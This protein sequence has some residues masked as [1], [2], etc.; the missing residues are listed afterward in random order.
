[1][2]DHNTDRSMNAIGVLF[3]AG[4]ILLIILGFMPN[5]IT[6]LAGTANGVD[7][8]YELEGGSSTM[9][10]RYIGVK[11]EHTVPIE[12]P[13]Y[14]SHHFSGWLNSVDEEI[15]FPGETFEPKSDTTM[16][17]VWRVRQ[18]DI[19]YELNGGTGAF[20]VERVD[21]FSTYKLYDHEPTREGYTFKGWL[22]SKTG[23]TNYPGQTITPEGDLTF[24]AKWSHN[25]YGVSYHLNGGS[26]NYSNSD[27]NHGETFKIANT[28]P[29][30]T[31]HAFKGWQ[32]I[33]DDPA[34]PTTT[35]QPGE[36]IKIT[37][38]T[39]LNAQ[40]QANKY[41]LS[42]DL[43]GGSGSAK[44]VNLSYNQTIELDTSKPVRTGYRFKGW[45]RSDTGGIVQ[46]GDTFK[47]PANN[48]KLTAQW[49]INGYMVTYQ[50]NGGSGNYAQDSVNYNAEYT[51]SSTVPTRTGY[52]FKG[53]KRSDSNEVIDKGSRF[54]MPDGNISLTAQW[55]IESYR[56]SYNTNGGSG[57]FSS[58]TLNYNNMFTVDGTKPTRAGHI[59]KGWRRSDSGDVIQASD[60]FRTPANDVTLTAQ[61]TIN[62]YNLTYNLNGGHT[63]PSGTS[64][65]TYGE[66]VAV[67][68]KEPERPGY[69]FEGWK[70][71]DTGMIVDPYDSFDMP[72]NDVTLTA[73]WQNYVYSV[74]YG[75]N[76]GS[77]S[78][79]F[80]KVFYGETIIVRSGEPTRSGH[81]F[82]GWKRSD[83]AETVHAG[84]KIVVTRRMLLKAI[85][86]KAEYTVRFNANGG[87]GAP[88]SQV[89][90][91]GT[92]LRLTTSKPTRDGYTF[93]GWSTNASGTGTRYNSG[94]PYADNAGMNLYAQWK[95]NSYKII[96]NAG[97]GSSGGPGNTTQT[98]GSTFSIN[99]STIPSRP[100]HVFAGWKRS[101]NGRYYN[102]KSTFTM[103]REDVTLTA[104]WR[105]D[106][107]LRNGS[108]IRLVSGSKYVS[109]GAG[110]R[111][112]TVPDSYSIDQDM[113]IYKY[114]SIYGSDAFIFG[115]YSNKNGVTG[116]TDRSNIIY[117]DPDVGR[118]Y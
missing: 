15:Y 45:K 88:S 83:T 101:D 65:H 14:D 69:Y 20:S 63:G 85:W 77:G 37:G 57:S 22:N 84:D 114:D 98:Y 55:E 51:V 90:E 12:E 70:R 109:N 23:G 100:N 34:V 92:T 27:V 81:E 116:A 108:K 95:A 56:I 96:Y 9:E 97:Y 13:T 118:Y 17:A 43:D 8:V 86:D 47:M 115:P 105:G 103:P 71:S 5:F 60:R 28:T 44:D 25:N 64:K 107:Y 19:T 54:R 66:S 87:S 62:G 78:F 3:V 80:H 35:K 26:G 7:V 110:E 61:W 82:K 41:T 106:G 79:D 111:G 4:A 11:G 73:Q 29:T 38:A 33:S 48:L 58:K 6:S 99:R 32:M 50:L 36:S 1:M 74:S 52:L 89:K 10:K 2:L 93:V 117:Q 24:S 75:L 72:E 53:W 59:F 91:Y 46:P 18:H 30:R 68:S 40:W 21:Y 42:Y 112:K 39:R 67:D 102:P 49:Q 104:R 16:T 113:H 76:F 94:D 31:G